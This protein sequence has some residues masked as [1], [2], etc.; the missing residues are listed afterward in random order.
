[1]LSN[2]GIIETV[3]SYKGTFFKGLEKNIKEITFP[4][5]NNFKK[6]YV[7]DKIFEEFK[8]DLIAEAFIYTYGK[9]DIL[10]ITVKPSNFNCMDGYLASFNTPVKKYRNRDGTTDLNYLCEQFM[11]GFKAEYISLK[12]KRK[13]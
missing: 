9:E 11:K 5:I 8:N 4:S 3:F 10:A 1:M 2:Y 7:V 13:I 6:I 12:F